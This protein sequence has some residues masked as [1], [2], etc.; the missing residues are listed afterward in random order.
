[1]PLAKLIKSKTGKDLPVSI[2]GT[3]NNFTMK[4]STGSVSIGVLQGL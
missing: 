2:S 4:L 1:M 3:I